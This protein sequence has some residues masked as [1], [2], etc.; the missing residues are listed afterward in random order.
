MFFFHAFAIFVHTAFSTF[1]AVH[2][3]FPILHIAIHS[4]SVM[5]AAAVM[6]HTSV[7]PVPSAHRTALAHAVFIMMNHSDNAACD[8]AGQD[9]ESDNKQDITSPFQSLA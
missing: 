4:A 2:F 9:Q 8:C 5:T 3:A 7:M 6:H 1:G